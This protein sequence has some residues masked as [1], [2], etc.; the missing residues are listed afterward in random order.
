MPTLN[1]AEQLIPDYQESGT[2]AKLRI[3]CSSDFTDEDGFR[4]LASQGKFFL[5]ATCTIADKVITIP[6]IEHPIPSVPYLDT[7]FNAYLYTVRD[8]LIQ[9]FLVNYNIIPN[10]TTTTW[11]SLRVHNSAVR[12]HYGFTG[13]LNQGQIQVLIDAGDDAVTLALDAVADDLATNY[14]TKTTS[15][16]RFLNINPYAL[17]FIETNYHH[18]NHGLFWSANTDYKN[19]FAEFRIYPLGNGYFCSAGYGGNHCLLYGTSGDA[20]NGY[21]LS[22]NFYDDNTH[23]AISFSTFDRLRHGEWYHVALAYD[24]TYITCIINGVPSSVTPYTGKRRTPN[25]YEGTLL[26]GG[27]DHNTF[28]GYIS[29]VRIFECGTGSLPYSNPHNTVVRP[30]ADDS[31][32]LTTISNGSAEVGATFLA[33]YSTKLLTDFGVGQSASKKNDGFLDETRSNSGMTGEVGAY[34]RPLGLNRTASYRPQWI[35]SPFG[36]SATGASPLTPIATATAYDSFGRND[37]HFGNSTAL[38]LGNLEVGN[39]LW[40]TWRNSA[41]Y[42]IINGN[43]FPASTTPGI[44]WFDDG[45][46]NC[47]V[48]LYK[49]N[50]V[51]VT[52]LAVVYQMP[53]RII[54]LNNYNFL[55]VDEYGSGYIFQVEAGVNTGAVGSLTFGTSWTYCAVRLNGSNV[56]VIRDGSV[57]TSFTMTKNLTG[58]G[59][60]MLLNN[61]VQRVRQYAVL[62]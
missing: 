6:E 39:A 1:I 52:G 29:G 15:D 27:S 7:R 16:A 4:H 46:L 3:W 33:D 28:S 10:Q 43:V 17:E 26:I 45:V 59:K 50:S 14:Y 35:V 19:V 2:T 18:V 13:Y 25:T 30:Q 11:E 21:I 37:K 8:E 40:A 44:A 38:G 62:P 42:G 58:T 48:R 22:G 36:Y 5:E 57:L 53:F 49:T 61:P 31:F 55:Y 34:N 41:N 24:G 9:T 47:E 20:V 51:N 12:G 56:S 54:D 60:G 32:K 23:T